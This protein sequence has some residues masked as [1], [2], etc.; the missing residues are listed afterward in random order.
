MALQRMELRGNKEMKFC[1][2]NQEA[3]WPW[4]FPYP[5]DFVGNFSPDKQKIGLE[6]LPVVP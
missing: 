4:T 5:K 3:L 6:L 1:S 2:N